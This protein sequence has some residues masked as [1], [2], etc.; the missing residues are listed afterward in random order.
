MCQSDHREKLHRFRNVS[1]FLQRHPEKLVLM[2]SEWARYLV[3]TCY[4][5]SNYRDY[6]RCKNGRPKAVYI[7]AF[8]PAR[9]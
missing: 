3:K 5:F 7:Q 9:N 2:S 6:N 8:T 4:N 1:V